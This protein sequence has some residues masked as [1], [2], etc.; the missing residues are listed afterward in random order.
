MDVDYPGA[1]DEDDVLP[2]QDFEACSM[3]EIQ[4]GGQAVVVYSS[5][6]QQCEWTMHQAGVT[7][8]CSFAMICVLQMSC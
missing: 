1:D 4:L 8:I 6:G 7:K 2:L 3:L 5:V